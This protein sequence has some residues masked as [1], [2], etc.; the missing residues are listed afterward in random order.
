MRRHEQR[1]H[2]ILPYRAVTTAAIV[3]VQST[4]SPRSILQHINSGHH[5][6]RCVHICACGNQRIHNGDVT[7]FR[8]NK[9][10]CKSLLQYRAVTTV[11]IV[12]LHVTTQLVHSSRNI[13][14]Q[15]NNCGHHL[16]RYVQICF[17]GD[18][19]I[20]NGG[21]TILRRHEKRRGASLP[22]IAVTT[23]VIVRF[24]RLQRNW[25]IHHKT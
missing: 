25:L 9:Q 5:F 17:S 16:V 18:Q 15:H 22:Y 3:R 14:L 19:R 23:I 7:I 2:A 24:C 11:V 13:L 4:Q 6:G 21:V 20:H 1:R 10:R 12:M 8:R